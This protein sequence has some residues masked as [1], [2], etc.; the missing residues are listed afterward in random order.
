MGNNQFK[1]MAGKPIITGSEFPVKWESE[2]EANLFWSW[3]NFHTPLPQTPMSFDVTEFAQKARKQSTIYLGSYRSGTKTKV[4]NGYPYSTST[5]Q[6]MGPKKKKARKQNIAAKFESLRDIWDKEW[7][8]KLKKDLEKLKAV[9]YSD[10]SDH[11]LWNKVKQVLKIHANHWYIHHLVVL[12]IVEQSNQFEEVCGEVF[13]SNKESATSILLHGDETMTVRSIKGLE[14]LG[15]LANKDDDIRQI[16]KNNSGAKDAISRLK[17]LQNGKEW[18]EVFQSYLDEFGYRCTGFDLSFPTWIEDKTFVI[19][20]IS[21][22][23]KNKTIESS[24]DGFNRQS[25]KKERDALLMNAR[26]ICKSNPDLLKKFNAMYN[27]A[28]QLWPIKENHSHYIDQASTAMVRLAIIEV[29]RRLEAK[30]IINKVEDI[31]YIHLGEAKSALL[32]KVP[33]K[34]DTLISTRRLERKKFSKL[35]PP[36]YLGTFP[37]DHE[38]TSQEFSVDESSGT[39]R[40]TS[41]SAGEASGIARVIL[42]PDDFHKVRNGDILICRSTAPMWT[43]LFTMVSGLVSESG[44]VLSHPAVVAREFRIPSVV[45]LQNATNLIKDGEPITISG[46]DGLVHTG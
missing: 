23:V 12:P 25:L 41:A 28:Q 21:N 34:I 22:T 39:L 14:R 35:T 17:Q 10:L 30:S 36:K 32:G 3:D 1:S 9:N 2:N 37:P 20:I 42:S 6:P 24:S 46:S 33:D 13:K 15:D 7:L 44:G 8:P 26:E 43:P 11:S 5:T 18:L 38:D 45:G 31:W 40:G 4:I 16:L 27:L 29:G 19:K